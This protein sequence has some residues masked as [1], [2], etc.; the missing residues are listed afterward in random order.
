MDIFSM[1]WEQALAYIVLARTALDGVHRFLKT[2]LFPS[3]DFIPEEVENRILR[4]GA[5]G[6]S[7]LGRLTGGASLL[8]TASRRKD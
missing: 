2:Q 1:D 5:M 4:W 7:F 3:T 8:N 6:L